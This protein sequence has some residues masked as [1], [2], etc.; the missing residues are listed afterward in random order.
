MNIIKKF[1][2][3]SEKKSP[4]D[5][6]NK[7]SQNTKIAEEYE[8]KRKLLLSKY[9]PIT[10]HISG[11]SKRKRSPSNESERSSRRELKKRKKEKKHKTKKKH[12]HKSN[13]KAKLRMKKSSSESEYDEEADKLKKLKLKRLRTE[14]LEREKEEK[15]KSEKLMAIIRGDVPPRV[16]EPVK[17]INGRPQIKRKYNSQFNPELAKQNYA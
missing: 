5:V 11:I 14:R 10:G 1:L 3:H 4:A 17:K 7:T 8:N 2:T 15:V 12:K 6:R 9:E 16:E 13:K